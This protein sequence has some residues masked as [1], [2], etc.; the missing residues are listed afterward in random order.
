M[1]ITE[2]KYFYVTK[3]RKTDNAPLECYGS[4]ETIENAL[5]DQL[6]RSYDWNQKTSIYGVKNNNEVVQVA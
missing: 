4:H 6:H 1:A 3:P 5:V 2:F